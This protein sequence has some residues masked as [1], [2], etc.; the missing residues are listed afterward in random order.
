MKRILAV[1]LALLML[2][3]VAAL[4]EVDNLNLEGYPIVNEPITLRISGRME[5]QTTTWEGNY[6]LEYL[7]E[8]TGIQFD[9]QGVSNE[10]WEQQKGLMFASDDLPDLFVSAYF[11]N[12][13]LQEYGSEG[14]LIP[15]NDLIEEYMPNLQAVLEKYPEG[16]AM[17]TS[18]D[19][20]IYT[21]PTYNQVVRD[22]HNRNF[23]NRVWVENL[24]MEMPETLDDLYEIFKAFKEQDA[25]GNGDTN[26][27]IPLSGYNGQNAFDGLVLNALGVNAKGANYQYTADRDGKVYCVNT[28]DAY[29]DYLLFMRKLYAEGL[30]DQEFFTQTQ[31]QYVAKAQQGI[32]GASQTGAMYI[33]CGTE[34]GYD[35]EQIDGLLSDRN[36]TRMVTASTGISTGRVAITKANPYP[37]A[38]ARLLD[39]F[40]SEEGGINWYVGVEGISWE[41]IDKEAGTWEK[42]APEEYETPEVFRATVATICMGWCGYCDPEFNAGQ[43]S[44]N[45]MYL[46]E[47]SMK[48]FPYFVNEFPA[49][50][51][52]DED[53]ETVQ[54]YATDLTTYVAQSRARFITGEDDIEAMWDSYVNQC[55]NMGVTEITEIYQT[56][57]DQYLAMME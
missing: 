47:M 55:N 38:T 7:T 6:Q 22:I 13:E 52:N 53:N 4:A 5:A 9:A 35:Y 23:L 21:L 31:E 39:Y 28:C 12:A 57:Y 14:L 8:L 32:V 16:K 11:S 43:G 45:A 25:N 26:D 48:S 10:A 30:L 2:C 44:A 1:T 34:I 49:L 3:S 27:E 24:G 20:N 46:N 19:G 40:F 42:I 36:D 54:M 29:K 17:I 15:L 33:D 56:Y 37:E 41:W 50:A 51:L 18:A